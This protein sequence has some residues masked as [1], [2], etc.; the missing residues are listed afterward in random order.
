MAPSSPVLIGVVGDSGSGKSTLSVCIAEA[1]G[2]ARA[3]L[4][5][6]DDYHRYDRTERER[7]GITALSPECNRLDL[8][9]DHLVA[10]RRGHAITKPVY[11]HH[12]GTFGADEVVE[13]REVI[14]VRG[15][16]G[17]HTDALAGC[18][19]LSV[20]L[21][22]DPELRVRWKVGRDCANR[23]YSR[24]QVMEKISHRRPD[25]DRFIA[26]Q[27]QRADLVIRFA[28]RAPDVAGD[29]QLDM[30]ITARRVAEHPGLAAAP[31]AASHD[32]FS[33]SP[34]IAR[35][36]AGQ[37]LV[38]LVLGAAESARDLH[39]AVKSRLPST[40]PGQHPVTP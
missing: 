36:P 31:I 2:L 10:L 29:G 28:P 12:D 38:P 13:P 9:A 6:L 30:Q 19:D 34:P 4:I 16:L 37:V 20:F 14:V 24:E 27:R 11:D 22:P 7:R 8:V 33:E 3:T 39:A 1:A 26:P 15:L 18:F 25:A 21:D 32:G 5:C 35:T 40:P 17:L 23:G